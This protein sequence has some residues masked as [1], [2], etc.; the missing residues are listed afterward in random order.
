MGRIQRVGELTR[1]LE[2]LVEWQ[3]PSAWVTVSSD[4]IA[5]RFTIH[6]FHDE[7]R[8][9]STLLDSE[10]GGDVGMDQ[11]REG[12]CFPPEAGKTLR[13]GGISIGQD[14][15]RDIA[16]QA[17]VAGAVDFAHSALAQQFHDI[18]GSETPAGLQRHG[19]VA[20]YTPGIAEWVTRSLGRSSGGRSLA[21]Q[22]HVLGAARLRRFGFGKKSSTQTQLATDG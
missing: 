19:G 15:Q 7:S 18:E 10:Q 2:H 3:P 20:D 14:L 17:G 6:Q 4:P 12:E 5:E 21:E 22:P 16:V 1:K 8:R 13:V 9:N 11:R